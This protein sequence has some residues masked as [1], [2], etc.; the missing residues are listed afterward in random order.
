MLKLAD[1]VRRPR[2]AYV[3]A[4]TRKSHTT[5]GV[6]E[7]AIKNLEFNCSYNGINEALKTSLKGIGLPRSHSFAKDDGWGSDA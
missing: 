3:L 1:S 7:R 2:V 5:I 4:E 6:A